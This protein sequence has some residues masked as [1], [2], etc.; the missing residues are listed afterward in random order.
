MFLAALGDIFSADFTKADIPLAISPKNLEKSFHS[1]APTTPV[2][3]IPAK[4]VSSFCPLTS[5]VSKRLS[6]FWR[7]PKIAVFIFCC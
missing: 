4:S 7:V 6:M 1:L 3:L 2:S 5:P